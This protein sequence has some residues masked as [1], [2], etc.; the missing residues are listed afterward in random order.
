MK[1]RSFS[2]G[3]GMHRVF[4]FKS[5][6]HVEVGWMTFNK[7]NNKY[8]IEIKRVNFL[9]AYYEFYSHKTSEFFSETTNLTKRD[10]KHG[11]YIK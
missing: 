2:C 9:I 11:N 4:L 8:S 6:F 10:F 3:R 5:L 7:L 1:F